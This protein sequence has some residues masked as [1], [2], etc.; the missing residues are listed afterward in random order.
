MLRLENRQLTSELQ[1]QNEY[2]LSRG[3]VPGKF[4]EHFTLSCIGKVP[5]VVHGTYEHTDVVV[6]I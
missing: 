1:R 6:F 5:F 3:M 2:D 4:R